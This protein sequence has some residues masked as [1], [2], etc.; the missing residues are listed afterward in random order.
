MNN[1][2]KFAFLTIAFWSL[3]FFTDIS[4][5]SQT[6]QPELCVAGFCLGENEQTVK[7]KLRDYSPRYDNERQQPKYFFYNEYGTQVMALTTLSKER[8]FLIVGIEVFAVDDSYQKKHFQMKD[9]AAFTSDSGFFI[10]RRPSATS[11]IFG[12]PNM[13]GPKDVIKRQGQPATDEKPEKVRILRY[14]FGEVKKLE[15]QE[16]NLNGVNFGSYTA[17]YRFYKNNLRRIILAV[18]VTLANQL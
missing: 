14:K 10:G 18:K 5:R 1:L 8:L 15:D 6:N 17:E 11:M 3:I 16:T 13:T 4:V 12:V 7:A 2:L 9:T